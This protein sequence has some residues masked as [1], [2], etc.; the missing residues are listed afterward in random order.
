MLFQIVSE[1]DDV[2]IDSAFSNNVIDQLEIRTPFF[3]CK[4]LLRHSINIPTLMYALYPKNMTT[5]VIPKVSFWRTKQFMFKV[6]CAYYR[7]VK[8]LRGLH[9]KRN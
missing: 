8:R 2:D 9:E 4:K 3:K 7:E 5:I 6:K 1:F